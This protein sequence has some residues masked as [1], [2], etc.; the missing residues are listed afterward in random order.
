MK[1]DPA[2]DLSGALPILE[3]TFQKHSGAQVGDKT[4]GDALLPWIQSLKAGRS[5]EEALSESFKAVEATAQ[6][7]GKFGRSKY[8]GDRSL[9]TID[10]GAYAT[11]MILDEVSK[12][13]H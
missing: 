13:I 7:T 10:P 12:E 4:M 9:G 6:Q 1:V 8:A 11:W 5:P 2:P 3:A